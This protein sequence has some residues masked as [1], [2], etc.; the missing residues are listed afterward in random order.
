M[1][2]TVHIITIVDVDVVDVC[3]QTKIGKKSIV[4]K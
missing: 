4:R 2:E 1:Y 3:C